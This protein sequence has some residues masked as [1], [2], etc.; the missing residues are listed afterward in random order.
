MYE[1]RFK[2]RA[3]Q[4]D[5][6]GHLNNAKYLEL[7]EW[8]R[9][10]MHEG[11]GADVYEH[12]T[13][14]RVGP[15]VVHVDVDFKAEVHVG[16]EDKVLSRIGRIGNRSVTLIQEMYKEDGTLAAKANFIWTFMDFQTRKAAPMP[17]ELR[18]MY[19]DWQR[20]DG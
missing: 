17:E 5:M 20:R 1:S 18:Q 8:A 7:F 3:T 14:S 13:R 15:I 2:I 16:D 4:V 9:W 6:F 10:E 12:A 19:E 11:R